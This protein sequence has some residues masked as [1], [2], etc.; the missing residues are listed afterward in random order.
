MIKLGV[1]F[2]GKSCEHD[3]SIISGQ[4]LIQNVDKSKYSVIP[5]YISRDGKWYTGDKLL[6]TGFMSNFNPSQVQ[7]V[8][9]T[10]TGGEKCLYAI[11]EGKKG[12]FSSSAST[13]ETIPLDV[14]I[15]SMHGLHGEDGTI[16]G[17]LELNGI[18]YGG[19]GV[20]GCSVGMD[21]IAM[22]A[23]FRGYGFPVLED[24]YG[25]RNAYKANPEKLLEAAENKL[26]Y[27]MFVKPANLGSSIGISKAKDREGLKQALEIAF[28]YDRRVLIE[29]GVTNLDEVNCSCLGYS[30]DVTASVC[31]MPVTFEDMM[32]SFNDKYLRSGK[33][34]GMHAL[35]RKIPA[36]ISEEKTKEIQGLS[37]E[38]FKALD[39]KGVVRIDYLIDKDADKVFV[40]EINIIPGSFSFYL[41]EPTGLKYNELIDKLVDYAFKAW[42][43]NN[44]NNYAYDS[45]ILTKVSISGTKGSKTGGTKA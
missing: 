2:G 40:G 31:E 29:K 22:K 24:V 25:E 23:V 10:A 19:T 35:S 20:M 14:A 42:E 5:V 7:E 27:P 13:T 18:P 34:K 12:L 3:V 17:L 45:E 16:Q 1:F 38:I 39:C 4:Q 11:K 36:P 28:N 21:K 9:M 26:G 8:Y 44:S 43:D 37:V 41:W 32:L 30:N 15:I 6:D 33:G